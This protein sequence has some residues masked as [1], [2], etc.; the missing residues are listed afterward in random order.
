MLMREAAVLCLSNEFAPSNPIIMP[1][2]K[3]VLLLMGSPPPLLNTQ[4][5]TLIVILLETGTLLLCAFNDK[6]FYHLLNLHV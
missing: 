2:S 5:P 3:C 6:T 4:P 1:K